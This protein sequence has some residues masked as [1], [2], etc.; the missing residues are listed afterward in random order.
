MIS[1]V[2]EPKMHFTRWVLVVGWL[3]VVCEP[4]FINSCADRWANSKNRSSK[5]GF[6][7]YLLQEIIDRVLGVV[8]PHPTHAIPLLEIEI[9]RGH[10][11]ERKIVRIGRAVDHD[12]EILDPHVSRYHAQLTIDD[13]GIQ[14]QDLGSANGLRIDGRSVQDRSHPLKTGDTIPNSIIL[15]WWLL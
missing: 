1:K 7:D 4:Q 12:L 14:V 2:S 9:Q 3:I 11:R 8:T 13:R 10:H 6:H 5:R 15:N